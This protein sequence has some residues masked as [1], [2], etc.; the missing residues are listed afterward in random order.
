[1]NRTIKFRAMTTNNNVMVYGDLIHTPDN[2][3]RI[4]WFEQKDDIPLDVDFKSFNKLVQSS[5]IGQFTGL[6]DKNGKEVF[7]KDYLRNSKG[8]IGL[9]V[10]YEAGFY[11]E[12]KRKNGD[13]FMIVLHKG[14]MLNKEIIGNIFETPNLIEP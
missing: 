1:M 2:T 5:T 10:H 4:I 12:C 7:E 14:F 9:V 11:L 3:H 6:T 13:V 8:E